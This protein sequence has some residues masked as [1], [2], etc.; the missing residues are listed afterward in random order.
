MSFRV[1]TPAGPTQPRPPFF[2][3]HMM[4]QCGLPLTCKGNCRDDNSNHKI[5][6]KAAHTF[7]CGNRQNCFPR[8]CYDMRDSS[9]MV[10]LPLP[11][12]IFLPF[13]QV[14]FHH[15][16]SAKNRF[17]V[18]RPSPVVFHNNPITS[19][20]FYGPKNRPARTVFTTT[21]L[22]LNQLFPFIFRHIL[23]THYILTNTVDPS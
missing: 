21:I 18:S 6:E 12:A 23:K 2:R 15:S 13:I 5:R 10:F 16:L 11:K 9:P 1:I 14:L 17:S 7:K 22:P 8:S 19:Q 4:P 20:L 3:S